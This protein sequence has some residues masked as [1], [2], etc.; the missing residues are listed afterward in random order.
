MSVGALS[1]LAMGTMA[2]GEAL[3]AS[4]DKGKRVQT[5]KLPEG[6]KVD[7]HSHAILPSYINGM[8][9]LGIEPVQRKV[10]PCRPGQWRPI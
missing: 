10:F 7:F 2:G 9:E 1:L 3:A 5:I 4:S 8:K 6:K